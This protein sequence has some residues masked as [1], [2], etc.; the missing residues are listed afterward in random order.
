MECG[1]SV[2]SRTLRCI[3]NYCRYKEKIK[4]SLRYFIM[5]IC[6]LNFQV[7]SQC[8]YIYYVYIIWL[9]FFYRYIH[10]L[11]IFYEFIFLNKVY[12]NDNVFY[13]LIFT[14]KSVLEMNVNEEELKLP[15]VSYFYV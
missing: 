9:I 14:N 3:N 11:I 4:Y 13:K 7:I 2:F 1:N 5:I 10:V 15:T 12:R 6:V 8:E